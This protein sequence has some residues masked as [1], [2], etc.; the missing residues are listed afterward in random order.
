[1]TSCDRRTVLR[2]LGTAVTLP[3]LEAFRGGSSAHAASSLSATTLRSAFMF[4]PNGVH[5]PD[6][7]P[8]QQVHG[9]RGL[10]PLLEPISGQRDR[11]SVLVGLDH[12][13]A[14]ALGDGPGD[15]A[16]SSACFLT[17]A[18]SENIRRGHRSR[19]FRR[20]GHGQGPS[21][22]NPIRFT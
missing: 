18:P 13:N 20:S 8:E 19:S 11:I 6:W 12:H 9:E 21:W 7:I 14:K 3:W 5:A 16:R 17:A 2:G 22:A 4:I 15:H 10:T 1:M